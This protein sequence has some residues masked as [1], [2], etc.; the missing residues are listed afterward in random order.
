MKSIT[1]KINCGWK[2]QSADEVT[3]CYL[4]EGE[5]FKNY[6][7]IFTQIDK[8]P[9]QRTKIALCLDC[10]EEHTKDNKMEYLIN[11]DAL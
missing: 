3:K 5:I 11:I 9:W 6:I 1:F 7:G 2:L 4:C 8:G 10:F